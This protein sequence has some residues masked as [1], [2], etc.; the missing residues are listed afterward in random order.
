MT[1]GRGFIALAAVILRTLDLRCDR[2]GVVLRV[3]SALQ[4][5]FASAPE[6]RAN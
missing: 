2:R 6:F 4:Y 1:A 5:T 3:L